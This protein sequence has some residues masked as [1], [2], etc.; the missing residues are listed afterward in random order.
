MD[1][2]TL[3]S[4]LGDAGQMDEIGEGYIIQLINAVPT[5]INADMYAKIVH[6]DALRRRTIQAASKIA[7]LGYSTEGDIMSQLDEA[8]TIIMDVRKEDVGTGIEM[9]EAYISKHYDMLVSIEDGKMV[10]LPSGFYDIDHMFNGFQKPHQYVVG[11][12]PGMG[13]SLW[14]TNVAD[15]L[16]KLG[17]RVLFFSLEMSIKQIT[18]RRLST[19]TG[20]DSR[21][22]DRY[23]NLS[24]G[25]KRQINTALG[26]LSERPFYIDAT[27]N[28]SA[29]TI[30]AKAMRQDAYYGVDVIIIDHFH[31]LAPD[32]HMS[33]R[34]LEM[35]ENSKTL[36]I[37]G[38]SI[39]CPVITLA[40]NIGICPVSSKTRRSS[41]KGGSLAHA[42]MCLSILPLEIGIPQLEQL[43]RT[44]LRRGLGIFQNLSQA[45]RTALN[46]HH[47]FNGQFRRIKDKRNCI[48]AGD[49]VVSHGHILTNGI[50]LF[51][52]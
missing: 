23:Y 48:W 50:K 29:A 47:N 36:A 46:S 19:I 6:Q 44:R 18:N 2:I 22:I 31:L 52:P 25:Q 24:D 21:A 34:D 8:E 30:R 15:Y 10:G 16:S 4:A 51:Y 35:N 11:G 40:T 7:N 42:D 3:T 37:I 41:S 38:K 12:R 9:P 32:K 33:R 43:M 20:I 27:P 28:L 39:N 45:N 13:K 5:S 17:Y 14:A 1:F 26:E 49:F